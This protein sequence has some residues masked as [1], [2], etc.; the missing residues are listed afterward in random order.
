MNNVWLDRKEKSY[1]ERIDILKECATNFEYF[2]K[3][4]IKILHP[5][6]GLIPLELMDFQK[7]FIKS[8]NDNRFV[9][10]T[11]FREGGFSTNAIMWGL[12][13]TLF[14]LD[15]NLMIGC[16]RDRDATRWQENVLEVINW[17]PSWMRP[18][19]G[20]CNKHH[21]YFEETNSSIYFSTLEPA[22]GRRLDCI[23]IDEAAFHKKMNQSW[24]A[25]WP[26]LS[27]GGQCI[28]VSTT[29]GIGNWFQET[30]HNALEGKNN[31]SVF[32]SNYSEHPK[33]QNEEFCKLLRSNLGEAGW[34]Q[35]VLQD[36]LVDGFYN[37]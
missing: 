2:G 1:L 21:I 20:K 35:E 12:W 19:I 27:C 11:K 34:H 29:N 24:R 8:L 31:F 33:Y 9:I 3:N 5:T 7:R 10:A 37:K 4:Y 17:I 30:Y 28:A 16:P 6:R 13:K 23:I 32:K 15:Y 18:K 14:T 36:F 26:C 25:L 22:R